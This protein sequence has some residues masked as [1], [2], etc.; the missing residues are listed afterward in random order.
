MPPLRFGAFEFDR[1]THEL[2]KAG[3]R[4]KLQEQPSQVLEA[5]LENAGHVVT[6]DEFRQRVWPQDTF[7]DFDHSL[8][9]AINKIREALD[10]RAAS[11]RFVETIP[12]RGYRFLGSIEPAADR[13]VRRWRA[14]DDVTMWSGKYD[15]E[16]GDVAIIQ[17]DI[18]RSI[19][20]ELR[21]RDIG[22]QR[23][24]RA[25]AKAYDTYL[26][27]ETLAAE[28]SPGNERR[29]LEAIDLLQQ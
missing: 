16:V 4:V 24:Y 10:D 7:V 23:L 29:L 15:R 12:R 20:N 27:A 22:G 28:D 5:L 26:K 14:A 21:L 1:D 18:A 8:N 2:F 25:D 3:A 13:Q 6:R 9:I 11:P 19:V 17:N